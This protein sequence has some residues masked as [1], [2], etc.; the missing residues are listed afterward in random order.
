M[1]KGAESSF[2]TGQMARDPSLAIWRPDSPELKACGFKGGRAWQ[3]NGGP[4]R[5][6]PARAYPLSLEVPLPDSPGRLKQISIVGVFALYARA[7]IEPNGALGGAL[8]IQHRGET[9]KRID[10]IQGRHYGDAEDLTSVF[11][12]I[13]DGTTLETVGQAEFEVG[14]YRVDVLRMDIPKGVVADGIV[15]AD[16]GTPASFAVFDVVFEFEQALVCPFRGAGDQIGLN[17]LGK[18][19]RMRDGRQFEAALQQ[20]IQSLSKPGQN[21]DEARGLVLT[22]QAAVT[23]ALLE[24]GG[25]KSAHRFLLDS[26]RK[27]ENLESGRAMAEHGAESLRILTL[28][29]F[30]E[31]KTRSADLID[32]AIEYIDKH[33]AVGLT[34][35]QVAAHVGMS[36]SH[37]RH[38]FR[39]ATRQSFHKYVL[40]LRLERAK[41]LV[42]QTDVSLQE[43]S[44]MVGFVSPAHF[45]RAFSS[46]F[47]VAPSSLRA[48][49]N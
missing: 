8:R 29:I 12:R 11:R 17:E 37:F 34:D 33:F 15:L 26:V 46:R 45:S 47:G 44:D 4:A 18:I 14:T 1:A 20:L 21:L 2:L 36:T 9:V 19:L 32:D 24:M 31:N 48:A 49:K 7:D 13:G 35:E 10:L 41:E 30:G 43:I 40:G 3:S 5:R 22:F 28:P 38:L 42:L 27:M 16:L 39:E 25:P 6:H 23:A